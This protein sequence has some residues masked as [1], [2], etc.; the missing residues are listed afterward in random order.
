MLTVPKVKVNRSV[1]IRVLW[2]FLFCCPSNDPFAPVRR[3][4]WLC[5][6]P[7]CSLCLMKSVKKYFNF[8]QAKKL[9]KS[10]KWKIILCNI[11][12]LA[13]LN[14]FPV[15]KL[16]FGHFWNCKK[17]NLVKIKFLEIDL[18]DFTI[19]FGLDFF[20]FSLAYYPATIEFLE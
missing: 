8:V 6:H 14:F 15:Q 19:F 7:C 2:A 4:D 13:V 10:N 18:F 5:S 9:V 20:K 12:F 16:I 17:W 3:D 11:A 1:W